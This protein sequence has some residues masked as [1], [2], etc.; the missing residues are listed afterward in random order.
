MGTVPN[1]EALTL[2]TLKDLV[3]L[4]PWKTPT[5]PFTR[6]RSRLVY[7]KIKEPLL[8]DGVRV[9]WEAMPVLQKEDDNVDFEV[10]YGGLFEFID[11]YVFKA[12]KRGID[13][14]LGELLG[15]PR[16]DEYRSSLCV[17]SS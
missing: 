14:L 1:Y 8:K 5:P 15:L 17:C 11:K 10:P 6:S 12:I 3:P 13:R 16:F 2:T 7:S 9:Y 4:S